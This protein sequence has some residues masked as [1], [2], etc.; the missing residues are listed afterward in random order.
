MRLQTSKTKN[1]ESFYIV[2]SIYV[3]GKRSN[4]IVKKLG[5]LE[6]IR[7]KIG[8]DKDPYEWGR[9]Q[10]KILT[11][12]QLDEKEDRISVQYDPSRRIDADSSQ[13]FSVGYLFLQKIYCELGIPNLCRA[14]SKDYKFEYDLDE[15]FSKLIYA[16]S[17]FPSSKKGTVIWHRSAS[18]RSHQGR[19]RTCN[20]Y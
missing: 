9:E 20:L 12:K 1:A 7:E 17:L 19:T 14:I 15:I 16:R 18:R 5:T 10:A 3:D 11:Q 8:P 2:E 6:Q 13:V 4:K